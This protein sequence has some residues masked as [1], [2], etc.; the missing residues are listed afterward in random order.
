MKL[1]CHKKKTL[2]YVYIINRNEILI[3]NKDKEEKW[4]QKK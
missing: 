3:L 4:K 2:K 1:Y